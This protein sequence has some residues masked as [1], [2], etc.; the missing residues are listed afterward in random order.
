[1]PIWQWK[2]YKLFCEAFH[3]SVKEISIKLSIFLPLKHLHLPESLELPLPVH[4]LAN[5]NG[6]RL[7]KRSSWVSGS[8]RQFNGLLIKFTSHVQI[9]LDDKE[10]N[11]ICLPPIHFFNCLSKFRQNTHFYKY[12]VHNKFKCQ[13]M[14]M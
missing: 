7:F 6:Q 3:F 14:L 2:R 13:K 8:A 9:P 10:E 12:C 11:K 4:Q 1:M 5:W